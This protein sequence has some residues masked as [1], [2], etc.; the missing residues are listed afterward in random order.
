MAAP[1]APEVAQRM[2][3]SAIP[4][5]VNRMRY[6]RMMSVPLFDVPQ[7]LA[8]CEARVAPSGRLAQRKITRLSVPELQI[9][10]ASQW[11]SVREG[12]FGVK[13]RTKR[14]PQSGVAEG[15]FLLGDLPWSGGRTGGRDRDVGWNAGIAGWSLRCYPPRTLA[16]RDASKFATPFRMNASSSSLVIRLNSSFT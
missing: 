5:P 14:M 16:R 10:I 2:P 4:R 13:Y 1:P 11:R 8:G 7:I 9:G 6:V 15:L 12:R 3:V